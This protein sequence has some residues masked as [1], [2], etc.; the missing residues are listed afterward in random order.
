MKRLVLILL[1]LT[2][3][4]TAG[5][6]KQPQADAT[7]PSPA[8]TVPATEA[9]EPETEPT[10]PETEPVPQTVEIPVQTDNAPAVLLLLNRGDTVD[11]VGGYDEQHLIIKTP[12]GYGLVQK[13]LLRTEGTA[14]YEG[15]TGYSYKGTEVCADFQLLTEPVMTLSR[16]DEVEVLEELAEC[17]L[18][19]VE[20]TLGFV[21][22]DGLSRS[23]LRSS[24]GGKSGG[25]SGSGGADGGDISMEYYGGVQLLSGIEQSGEVTGTA[26][27]LCDGVPVVLWYFDRENLVPVVTEEGFAPTWEGYYTLYLNGLYA[28]MPRDLALAPDAEPIAAWEGY[29]ASKTDVYAD[30]T[31]SGEPLTRLK[32]NTKITVLWETD[33]CY[34]IQAE[35][36][37]GCI[38]K[39]KADTDKFYTGGGGSSSSSGGSS[40]GGDWTPPAL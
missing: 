16:N 14:P 11:V 30:Y 6:G 17:Y 28:Y 40:S 19:S 26:A 7:E 24:G 18:I 15:W 36:V 23:Y 35:E 2:M 5:C 27:V 25:S 9:T 12:Q 13:Q 34:V 39:E 38:P 10:V 8:P 33:S 29:S 21:A 31:L 37:I 3:L 32:V 20:G 4:V 1:I 22:K